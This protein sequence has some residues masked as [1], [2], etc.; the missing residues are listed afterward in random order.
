[1]T[2]RCLSTRR[3][4]DSYLSD[5]LPEETRRDVS[6]H[7]GS[8]AGCTDELER[9]RRLREE[10]RSALAAPVPVGL[11]ARV[12]EAVEADARPR[13]R[14][15]SRATWLAAAAAV[16]A[17]S[18]VVITRPRTDP[19]STSGAGVRPR[20]GPAAVVDRAAT[21][22]TIF[23]DATRIHVVCGIRRQVPKPPP[24]DR[25][26]PR[27]SPFEMLWPAVAPEMDGRILVD[28]HVCPRVPHRKFGHI[29]LRRGD[30]VVSVLATSE[31]HGPLPGRS[32]RLEV[33]GLDRPVYEAERWGFQV[34][35]VELGDR[36][37]LVVS[38]R[39]AEDDRA[40]ALRV[41]PQLAHAGL[42]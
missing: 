10:L 40:F 37:A 38:E 41:L 23:D 26:L 29:V 2:E 21:D 22:L 32:E 1:V 14:G 7:L 20:P 28:A 12:R 31:R 27:L 13:P 25:I 33:A 30:R 11:E 36:V 19:T 9:R 42:P 6:R 17:A 8:C 4:L 39:D 3:E 24:P 15:A 34:D 18:A 16:L 5:E 35:A